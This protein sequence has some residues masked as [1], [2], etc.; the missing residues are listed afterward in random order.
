VRDYALELLKVQVNLEDKTLQQIALQRNETPAE[1]V[2]DLAQG[3]LIR[4]ASF[5]MS[6]KDISNFMVKS[7]VVTSSDGTDGH[8]RK[9]AS[10]P[11]NI[12]NMLKKRNYSV[13]NNS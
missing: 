2:L 1:T 10:F 12:V 7:W 9:Y 3:A 5:N 13:L 11:K 4:V 8:P 6:A